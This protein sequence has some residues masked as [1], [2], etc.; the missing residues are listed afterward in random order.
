MDNNISIKHD[1]LTCVGLPARA[2]SPQVNHFREGDVRA[3]MARGERADE[4]GVD[5][6]IELFIDTRRE[7]LRPNIKSVNVNTSVIRYLIAPM[8]VF[9]GGL[10]SPAAGVPCGRRRPGW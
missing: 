6:Q 9:G 7:S 5:A 8:P 2:I 3:S 1:V 10:L 4:V